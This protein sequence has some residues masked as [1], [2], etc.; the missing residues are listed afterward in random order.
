MAT[1][2]RVSEAYSKT[3]AVLSGKIE[4][5]QVKKATRKRNQEAVS[6]AS[7]LTPDSVA[8]SLKTIKLQ[9]TETFDNIQN[10]LLTKFGNVKEIEE[11]IE[12]KQ[13]QLK[14]LH[15]LHSEADALAILLETKKLEQERAR[16]EQQ[17][18][19]SSWLAEKAQHEKE[20]KAFREELVTSRRREEESYR[21]DTKKRRQA[22]EDVWRQERKEEVEAFNAEVSTRTAELAA[23]AKV[24]ADGE[25]RVKELEAKVVEVETQAEKRTAKEV[26]IATNALKSNLTHAFELERKDFQNK[27]EKLETELASK[28]VRVAELE[29]RNEELN[30]KYMASILQVQQIAERAIDGASKQAVVVQTPNHDV[31]EG[32][33][34]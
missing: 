31:S 18:I 1:A 23:E 4:E 27:V 5:T 8:E 6:Q 21:Y 20:D 9:V 10:T 33:K 12:A 15:D 26:A 7:K 11:A 32:R 29:H 19:R 2:T 28:Q 13:E 34:R 3:K 16:V 24:F 22:D 17:E 14:E 25:V 30:Q